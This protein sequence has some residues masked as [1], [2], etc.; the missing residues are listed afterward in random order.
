MGTL[1]SRL[2]STFRAYRIRESG[3]YGS[4][5]FE[6][7]A[8]ADL[9]AGTVVVRVAYASVN[10]KDALTA[11]G[12]AREKFLEE[13]QMAN[14]ICKAARLPR[15]QRSLLAVLRRLK[16]LKDSLPPVR[17]RAPEYVALLVRQARR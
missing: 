9:D 11:R 7:M 6:T 2:M 10:C 16:P 13:L 14:V 4:G 5:R 12:K 17:D 15:K 8:R 1:E 3:K